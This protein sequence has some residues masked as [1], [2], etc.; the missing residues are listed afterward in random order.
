MGVIIIKGTI[1]GLN[2][3]TCEIAK[4]HLFENDSEIQLNTIRGELIKRTGMSYEQ[5]LLQS[6]CCNQVVMVWN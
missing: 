6:D 5:H 2:C 4:R 3:V 1:S